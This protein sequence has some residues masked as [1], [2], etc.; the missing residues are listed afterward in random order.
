MTSLFI[1]IALVEEN[2]NGR[3]EPE[4]ETEPKIPNSSE[5]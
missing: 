4:G 2:N 1:E 5:F 3:G